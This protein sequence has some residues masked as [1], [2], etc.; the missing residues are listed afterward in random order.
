MKVPCGRDVLRD[1]HHDQLD[2]TREQIEADN[3]MAVCSRISTV[4]SHPRARFRGGYLVEP[5][6]QQLVISLHSTYLAVSRGS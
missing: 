6:H 5:H 2:F 1:R 3:L 4:A